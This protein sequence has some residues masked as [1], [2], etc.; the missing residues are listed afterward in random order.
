MVYSARTEEGN[1]DMSEPSARQNKQ[2]DLFRDEL[3]RTVLNS[4]SAHIAILDREGLI[5]ETNTAWQLYAIRNG[6]PADYDAR[7]TN[8]LNICD[9]SKGGGATDARK[10]AEGIRGVIRGDIE[11]FLYD[12]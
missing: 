6:M 3:A 2:S 10:V 5:L 1:G 12:Y 9:V 8:Y 11:E 7:G 4:L